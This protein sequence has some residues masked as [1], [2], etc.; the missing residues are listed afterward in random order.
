[1]ADQKIS[2]RIGADTKDLESAF[3]AFIKKAQGET[4]KLKLTPNAKSNVPGA[5]A[6]KESAQTA[7]A[8]N[9]RVREE[10]AGLDLVNRELEKKRALIEAIAKRQ[11]TAVKGSTEELNLT[12]K[13][14]REK[15]RLQQTEKVAQV[16]KENYR[17]AQDAQDRASGAARGAGGSG[18]AG[19]GGAA[20]GGFGNIGRGGITSISGLAGA[21]GAPAMALGIVATATAAIKA[22]E[23]ARRFF[24]EAPMRTREVE[25]SAFQ[26]QGQGGQRIESILNGGAA[27]ENIFDPQRQQ[28]ARSAQSAIRGRYAASPIGGAPGAAAQLLMGNQGFGALQHGNFMQAIRG[29]LGRYGVKSQQESFEANKKDEEADEQ[30]SQ[31]EAFKK[32]PEGALRTAVGNQYLQN[33]QRNLDFQRQTGL[34]TSA[35]RNDFLGGVNQ[36]GFTNEQGMGMASSIMGAGGSTRS[37]VG[38][39]ALGLQAQRNLDLT[40]AGSVIG[41]LSKGLGGAETTKEAFVK[42]LA[43]GTRAGLDNSEFREENRKF[44]EA[45]AGAI[46]QSG[47]TSGAGAEQILSQFG[48]FFSDKTGTGMEAGKNA[49]ELYRQTSMSTTGPRGTMRAAGMLTDPTIS[50]LSRDS[51]EALFN[52]PID[53]LT[54]DNPAIVAMAAQAGVSPDDLIKAQNKVTSKSANLFKNSDIATKRLAEVKKKYGRNSALDTMGP[55]MVG[56]KEEMTRALG[57]SNIAQIKEHPELGQNQR[58]LTA[59]SEALSRGDT[60]MPGQDLEEAKKQQLAAPTTGRPE[61]QTN[62]LQAEASRMSNQLF[63]SFK[64]SITPASEAVRK[65]ASDIDVLVAALKKGTPGGQAI[66]DFNSRYP[67][68]MPTTAPSAGSPGSGGGASGR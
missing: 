51:R 62:R 35:F 41:N 19:G 6:V 64:E 38:N 68:V 30:R 48:K 2:L 59:Y 25:A 7:R 14:N 21:L 13:L 17:K 42:I 24:V 29:T 4:E 36:A 31:F 28:A 34:G 47:V 65:F 23:S 11:E 39:A 50:K 22:V 1:M 55:F 46:T 56:E 12:Q 10:K 67:G 37:A 57:E 16:Q 5:E 49:Y 40:N 53:Q 61:D 33:Y 26:K 32:G 60:R 45:A 63:M 58:T 18:G 43:E 66:Q 3:S 20:A 8:I 9:Q 15:E 54:P 44:V 52:M 27:E